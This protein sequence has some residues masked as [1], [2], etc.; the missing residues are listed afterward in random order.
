VPRELGLEEILDIIEYFA[1]ATRNAREAGF[2]GVE[3]HGANGY[4]T[5]DAKAYSVP[6]AALKLTRG[7]YCVISNAER[8]NDGVSFPEQAVTT[9]QRRLIKASCD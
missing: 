3:L 9:N 8:G 1:K 5:S 4:T 2:D 7:A 6:P